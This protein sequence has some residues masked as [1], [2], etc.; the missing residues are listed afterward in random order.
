MMPHFEF[1]QPHRILL[2]PAIIALKRNIFSEQKLPVQQQSALEE[3][4]EDRLCIETE[5]T[6]SRNEQKAKCGLLKEAIPKH[7][8]KIRFHD[9]GGE[10]KEGEKK[11]TPTCMNCVKI[12]FG[13]Y[14]TAIVANGAMQYSPNLAACDWKNPHWRKV[15][16]KIQCMQH[17]CTSRPKRP[18]E[19]KSSNIQTQ[20]RLASKKKEQQR[21]FGD[22]GTH[23]HVNR[24]H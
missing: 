22:T 19:C 18:M 13:E 7:L 8:C 14:Q 16:A 11:N 20:R 10:E 9:L 6:N 2:K 24:R 1:S 21:L 23:S 5:N 4:R 3:S 12:T 15:V 17:V